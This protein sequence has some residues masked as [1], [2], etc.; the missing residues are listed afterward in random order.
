MEKE[1]F[2]N[3]LKNTNLKIGE[4]I[5]LTGE[6]IVAR[7]SA[8]KIIVEYLQ[9]KK[10][11]PFNLINSVI[12]YCGPS[13]CP[14]D[15][16]VGSAGPTTSK[17]MDRYCEIL[18]K[19]GVIATIGKGNRSSEHYELLKKYGCYYFTATGG[20]GAY[21]SKR[22]IKNEIIAFP[23]LGP[24]AIRKFYIKKF[25]VVVAGDKNSN[26]LFDLMHNNR[27]S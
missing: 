15:K 12:Y 25:P 26:N 1:I 5:L 10:E 2:I 16:I 20:A 4:Y 18:F 23:E 13:N 6:L 9:K 7:D 8:H 27:I 17:R 3:E 19:N 14:P 24:E 11:L 21:L 22:I